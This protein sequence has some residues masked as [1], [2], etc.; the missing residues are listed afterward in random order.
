MRS[1]SKLSENWL[2]TRI[3]EKTAR[4]L[5][6]R[7][8][9]PIKSWSTTGMLLNKKPIIER[10]TYIEKQENQYSSQRGRSIKIYTTLIISNHGTVILTTLSSR[11]LQ[12]VSYSSNNWNSN[13]FWK[14]SHWKNIVNNIFPMSS[15][16]IHFYSTNTHRYTISTVSKWKYA[17][18]YFN[19]HTY[20][21]L[22]NRKCTQP[23]TPFHVAVV[24][25]PTFNLQ[26]Y[27]RIPIG[28]QYPNTVHRALQQ[29][30]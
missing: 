17:C 4:V 22:N 13:E 28:T 26:R 14:K 11:S 15:S 3:A 18:A 2:G 7:P 5:M 20:K 21:L 10:W 19:T 25:L 8:V 24:L 23:V 29:D 30:T 6:V 27:V 1:N 9:T 16:S 12:F